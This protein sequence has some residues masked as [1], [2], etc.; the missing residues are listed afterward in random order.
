MPSVQCLKAGAWSYEFGGG[1]VSRTS[2]DPSAF[3]T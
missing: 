2:D 3:I 1:V